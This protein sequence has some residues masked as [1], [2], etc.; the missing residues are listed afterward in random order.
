MLFLN[1]DDVAQVLTMKVAMEAY[2]EGLR[3]YY[4]GEAAA[5]PRIDVWAPCDVPD[6]YFQW[7]SMEGTS[8]RWRMFAIRIKSDIAQFVRGGDDVWTHEYFCQQ[9]GKFCGLIWLFSLRNGEPLAMINDGILQHMRS[10][11]RAG[12]IARRLALPDARVVGMIGSGG[13]A[14]THAM[15]FKEARDIQRIQ[16]YSPTRAHREA[17]AREMSDLLDVEVVPQDRPEDAVRGA[18][19]VAC[20]TDSIVPVVRGEWIEEGALVTTVKGSI[21]LDDAAMARIDV[22]VGA[23]PREGRREELQGPYSHPGQHQAYVAGRPEELAGIPTAQRARP[24]TRSVRWMS[25]RDLI[26]GIAVGRT[27]EREVIAMGVG[28]GGEGEGTQGIAFASVGGATYQL[29]V[30]RRLGREIPTDWFLQDIRN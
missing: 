27:S 20:C 4:A 22:A 18:Q 19:I 13:M 5:R 17:Y 11:A 12:L 15:A 30:E 25:T 16:V 1:N 29:A 3:E 8:K 2:E 21:E 14:R 9:P 28:G 23:P 10:G 6:A 26:E 24:R 7:G